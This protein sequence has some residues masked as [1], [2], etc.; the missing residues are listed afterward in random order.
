MPWLNAGIK[1]RQQ[2]EAH[3]I[4]DLDGVRLARQGIAPW[5]LCSWS[6]IAGIL[7]I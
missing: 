2:Q 6:Y 5:V 7:L 3:I 1:L 4:A